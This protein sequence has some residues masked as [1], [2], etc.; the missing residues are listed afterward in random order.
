MV[1]FVPTEGWALDFSDDA[2]IY[3]SSKGYNCHSY[4]LMRSESTHPFLQSR[5]YEAELGRCQDDML[6]LRIIS[7]LYHRVTPF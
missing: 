6:N 7:S 3:H 4:S 2:V 5:L 1:L